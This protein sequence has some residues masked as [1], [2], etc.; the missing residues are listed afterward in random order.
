MPSQCSTPASSDS[1]DLRK[2]RS[3]SGRCDASCLRPLLLRLSRQVMGKN[4]EEVTHTQNQN[5]VL[6]LTMTE[7]LS[8][9]LPGGVVRLKTSSGDDLVLKLESAITFLGKPTAL[10]GGLYLRRSISLKDPGRS[11]P[12]SRISSPTTSS[13]ELEATE[14]TD[15]KVRLCESACA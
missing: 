2:A 6:V 1:C 14:L 9:I 4:Y 13:D 5:L 3:V 12:S 11:V 8:P 7:L 15:A 10:G